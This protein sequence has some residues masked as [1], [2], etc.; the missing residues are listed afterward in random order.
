MAILTTEE[1]RVIRKGAVIYEG[2]EIREGAEGIVVHGA[3]KYTAGCYYDSKVKS[4][5]IRLGCYHRSIG[6]W[7]KDFDNNQNEF[8]VDS[9]AYKK[10]VAVYSYLKG[11]AE[12]NLI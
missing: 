10:R 1:A 12:N 4:V 6:D 2:A 7:E 9:D 11:W 8:P 5:I 3:Y